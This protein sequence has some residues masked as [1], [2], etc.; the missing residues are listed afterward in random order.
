M[1][2][3]KEMVNSSHW[4]MKEKEGRCIVAIDAFNVVEKGYRS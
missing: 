2:T 4:Q 3:V 1:F